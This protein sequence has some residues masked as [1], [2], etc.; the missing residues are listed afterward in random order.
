M[1]E[2]LSLGLSGVGLKLSG[3]KWWMCVMNLRYCRVGGA[4]IEWNF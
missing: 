3:I 2:S 4:N 1:I